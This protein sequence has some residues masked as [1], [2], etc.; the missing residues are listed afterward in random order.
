M[1][2]VRGMNRLLPT[3]L[4]AV[5]LAGCAARPR[6]APTAATVPT[7]APAAQAPHEQ[8]G[9]GEDARRQLSALEIAPV[10]F[11]LDSS[12]L[13]PESQEALTRL[14]EAL[15]QRPRATV[16]VSGHT[17]EL[18]TTEYNLALGRRRAAVVES[19]LVRLGVEPQRISTLSYGEERPLDDRETEDARARN[20]RAEFTFQLGGQARD[21]AL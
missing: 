3:V 5:S 6:S 1:L 8:A 7:A 12:T 19:Y 17:C 2:L 13:T 14:A 9:P 18:G 16:Q 4:L 11:T 20:R 15:R 10:H 21:T